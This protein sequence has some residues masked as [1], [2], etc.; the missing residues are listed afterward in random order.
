VEADMIKDADAVCVLI[1]AALN[2]LTT[3]AGL[4]FDYE[5]L[6]KA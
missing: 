2:C 5:M 3:E 1:T 4:T 6:V